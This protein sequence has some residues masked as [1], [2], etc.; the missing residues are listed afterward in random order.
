[1][2]TDRPEDEKPYGDFESLFRDET[3]RLARYAWA[4]LR[5]MSDAE[6]LVQT[7][8]WKV[9]R[10]WAVVGNLETAAKQR[11]YFRKV[12]I[13]E[14][15][16][17]WRRR[18]NRPEVLLGDDTELIDERTAGP[19]RERQDEAG[20]E[21]RRVWP[22]VAELPPG[23]RRVIGLYAAGYEYGE[24]AEMLEISDS[25]VRSHMSEGRRRLRERLSGLR[26]EGQT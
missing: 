10:N 5:N 18:Q 17:T 9:L 13:N 6:D 20:A 23:A 4:E 1:M 22:A 8:G 16:Q 11:A 7:V 12:A 21:L 19:E 14:L 26:G 24:I 3:T 15:K 25:A 2:T